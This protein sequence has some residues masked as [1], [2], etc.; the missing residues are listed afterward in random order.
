MTQTGRACYPSAL[1]VTIVIS[2]AGTLFLIAQRHAK[3]D[4]N[5]VT[6]ATETSVPAATPSV[7]RVTKSLEEI[8]RNG[9]IPEL[10][11][12]VVLFNRVPKCGS[13]MLVLLMQWLQGA[14]GFR[15]VRLGGGNVRRLTTRQQVR[16]LQADRP[17]GSH[18]V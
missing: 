17:I 7:R 12:H 11:D 10:S 16:T 14:N 5:A 8:R 15:H 9:E 3:E 18:I 1:L 2:G 4:N 13:E 6:K